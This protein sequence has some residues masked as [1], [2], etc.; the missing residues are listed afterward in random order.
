MR[1]WGGGRGGKTSELLNPELVSSKNLGGRRILGYPSPLPAPLLLR[2]RNTRAQSEISHVCF[3]SGG[4]GM[5]TRKL[6]AR[7]GGERGAR[8]DSHPPKAPRQGQQF[9]G[10]EVNLASERHFSRTH[11]P[12]FAGSLKKHASICF[13]AGRDATKRYLGSVQEG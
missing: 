2:G 10:K 11:P 13:L 7:T 4:A 5:S 3:A 6:L 9:G 8:A 12:P 1:Q